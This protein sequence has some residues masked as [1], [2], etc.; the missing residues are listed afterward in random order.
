[1]LIQRAAIALVQVLGLA[2]WFSMSAVVPS[3]RHEWGISA[4]AAVWLTASVQLGFVTGA[5]GATVLNLADR[6]RPHLLLAISAAAGAG[7]TLLLALGVD[8]LWAAIPLRFLTGVALAG[9]YPVG[10]KLMASWSETRNRG[11]ALGVLIGALTLGSALPHVFGR[12]PW[13]EVLTT[14]AAIAFVGALV[15]FFVVRPGPFLTATTAQLNPRYAVQMFRERK[16]RLVNLGYFGHMW[17]LYALW[18]WLPTFLISANAPTGLAVFLTMGVAGA[19]GCLIGGWAADRFG[20]A[21]AA[22]GALTVSGACCLLSPLAHQ[23]GT[24]ALIA[25]CA[26]WGASVIADSGVFS[27]SL[28]EVADPRYVGTALTALTAIGFGLTVVSIQLVPLLAEVVTWRYAF[29]LLVP[30]PVIGAL[31]ML[32]TRS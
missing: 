24:V 17:E 5:V 4:G 27:T 26:V 2:V 6:V 18:T 22:V 25:F 31:A 23:A 8:G 11:R 15:A 21:P 14:A 29:L 3:L 19:V 13:R 1:M 12:L 7:F 28:S 20:R 30:G 10:M 16:P 9:V 32:R